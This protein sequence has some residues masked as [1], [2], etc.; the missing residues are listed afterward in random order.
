MTDEQVIAIA[1]S[2]GGGSTNTV[3]AAQELAE[4]S[5]DLR[6]WIQLLVVYEQENV[7]A[8]SMES[9]LEISAQRRDARSLRSRRE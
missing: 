2:G 3:Q 7:A 6:E 5:K 8:G 1:I 4:K 9:M